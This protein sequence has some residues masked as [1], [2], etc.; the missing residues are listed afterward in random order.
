[1]QI[2]FIKHSGF[3]VETDEANYVFDYV[4]GNLPAFSEDKPLYV[5]ASHAHQD[6]WVPGIFT[7]DVLKKPGFSSWAL[8]SRRLLKKWRRRIHL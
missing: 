3:S 1:M 7:H 4:K 8:I 5:F 6:H 2:T